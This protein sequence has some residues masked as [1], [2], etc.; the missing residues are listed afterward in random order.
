MIQR[1]AFLLVRPM[2]APARAALDV[3]FGRYH[4]LVIGI[5]DCQ[6]LP[7]LEPAVNDT[8]VTH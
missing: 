4:A 8:G 5:N 1:L 2:W 6:N 3:D 7:R